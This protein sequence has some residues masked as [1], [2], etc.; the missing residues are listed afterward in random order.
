MEE[1]R[2]RRGRARGGQIAHR[3]QQLFFP[4]S[5]SPLPGDRRARGRERQGQGKAEWIIRHTIPAIHRSM[6]PGSEKGGPRGRKAGKGGWE[7]IRFEC[8][9]LERRETRPRWGRPRSHPPG[10]A[11]TGRKGE[12]EWRG[13]VKQQQ[14]HPLETIQGVGKR[15]GRGEGRGR[16]RRGRARRRCVGGRGKEGAERDGGSLSQ[17]TRSAAFTHPPIPA[18]APSNVKHVFHPR[19]PNP[20]AWARTRQQ[21]GKEGVRPGGRHGRHCFE[22]RGEKF[23]GSC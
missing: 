11:S 18:R 14:K 9:F 17:A 7:G 16:N 2:R 1:A 6:E 3:G 23:K 12:K 10:P 22:G 21:R 20:P 13:R 4:P 15:A 8:L 19:Y 5:L